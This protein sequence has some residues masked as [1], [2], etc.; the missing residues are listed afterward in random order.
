MARRLL[1]PRAV[2][3]TA[4]AAGLWTAACS[5]RVDRVPEPARRV[6]APSAPASVSVSSPETPEPSDGVPVFLCGKLRP[7]DLEQLSCTRAEDDIS[8]E[9]A[10]PPLK[11]LEIRGTSIDHIAWVGRL[12][13][14][15]ELRLGFDDREIDGAQL[16]ALLTLP[17]LR[18]LSLRST[19]IRDTS[20]LSALRGLTALSLSGCRELADTSTLRGLGRLDYLDLFGTAVRDLSA[21]SQLPLE[22][23]NLGGTEVDDVEALSKVT[24]LRE[25]NLWGTFVSNVGPLAPLAGLT[26]LDLT[27]TD[28]S[29]LRRLGGLRQLRR[30][31]LGYLDAVE[32]DVLAKLERLE[33]LYLNGD[34]VRDVAPLAGLS[35]LVQLS[36]A[37]TPELVDV[38][39]IVKLKHLRRLDIRRTGVRDIRPLAELEH[40][41]T[42][43]ITGSRVSAANEAALRTLRPHL[44][45][46]WDPN[47]PRPPAAPS[48]A[49]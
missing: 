32:L 43:R 33:V 29:D 18:R 7:S 21:L 6:I 26:A 48:A 13:E 3:L 19:T 40:L 9:V 36:L 37:D 5:A 16:D 28:V 49:P 39:S 8:Q 20:A 44:E 22:R 17:S 27:H 14:L 47:L 23:L 31:L 2:A 34:G 12:E 46:E 15:E 4:L 30:L 25:L 38:S 35:H 1:T 11:R 24:T 42:V 45:I 41:Q 10:L